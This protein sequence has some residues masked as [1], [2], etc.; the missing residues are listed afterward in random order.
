MAKRQPLAGG[1]LRPRSMLLTVYGAFVRDLGGWVAVRDLVALFE[2][3]G[4]D[5]GALRAAVSRAKK[6]GTIHPEKVEGV[7][8]YRLSAS[9]DGLVAE[10]ERRLLGHLQ[11]AVLEDGWVLAV[12]SVP[13]DKRELRALIT[14]RLE[15]LGYGQMGAGIRIAPATHLHD[16]RHT[17]ERL[18]LTPYVHLMTAHYENFQDL[19]SLANSWWDLEAIREGYT[20]FLTHVS[21]VLERWQTSSAELDDRAAFVDYVRARTIWR[22][23]PYLDPGL[24]DELYPDRWPRAQAAGSFLMLHRLLKAPATRF[25]RE[26]T[27]LDRVQRAT[28]ATPARPELTP[29]SLDGLASVSDDTDHRW[30]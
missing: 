24:P 16:T 22:R 17:L 10:G 23:L 27:G 30:L 13:E 5:S 29:E 7:S 1:S 21:P 25:V 14:S 19:H 3:L 6:A 2:E 18:E 20:S 12:F 8:G 15:W 4:V 11:P 26:T 28:R 9:S